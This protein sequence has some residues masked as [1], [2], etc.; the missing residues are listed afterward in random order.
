MA[1]L[2]AH[3]VRRSMWPRCLLVLL[4]VVWPLTVVSGAF[5]EQILKEWQFNR[6][7]DLEGWSPGGHVRET[8]VSDGVLRTTVIDW[9]PILIH[10]VFAEPLPA[11]ATQVIEIR[12][13]AP[14]A[15]RAEFFWTNTTQTQY[16]GFSPGKQ[17][18]F[19]L[20]PGWHTYQVRPFWQAEGQIIR[21]RLDLPPLEGAESP[22]EY[23]IDF[24]R[25]LELGAGGPPANPDWSFSQDTR[26]WQVEGDGKIWWQDGCLQAEL[27]AGARLV[28]PPFTADADVVGFVSFE[29]A[30]DQPGSGRIFWA[31]GKVNGLQSQDF[32]L[33]S[34]REFRVYNIPLIGSKGW[35]SPLVYLAIAPNISQPTRIRLRWFKLTEE[36]AGP[37]DLEIERLFIRSALPRVGQPQE[38]VAR[39]ANRGGQTATRV[40]AELTLPAGWRVLEPQTPR[41]IVESIEFGD[42]ADVIWRVVS[43]QAGPAT[44]RV[45]ILSPTA[46][47]AACEENILPPMSLPKADYVPEPKPVRGPY[48]VGVY[49]FPGW[50]RPG[51]WVPI[52]GFPERRP[53]LG[54]YREGL[55]E[56]ADWHIKWAVEHGIT[57]FCY[58]WYWTQGKRMLEH[59]LHDGF[60]NARYRHLMKFCLLWANH[61]GPG[62]HSAEDNERVCR[63]WIENYFRRPEYFKVEGRPLVV[64]FSVHSMQRDLGIEGTRQAIELWHKMTEEAGVGKILVAGC[65]LPSQ[66]KKMKEMGFDAVS[67]YNWPSCGI[68]DRNWVP[69]AE[70]A[71]NYDRLWWRPLAEANLMPVIT[72]ISAG[73]DSRPWHGDK[74]LVITD[75]TPQA[76]EEHL[77]QARRFVEETHQPKV[78]LIE[79]WNEFGEGSYCEPHKQYGFGHLEAVRKVFCP[80]SPASL[81]Y[82]PEDVG[83]ALPEFAE[84][85]RPRLRTQWGFDTPGNPEGWEMMMGL[86][87]LQ[88]ADGLLT[89]RTT[90]TDP[91][92]VC[93]TRFRARDFVAL[94][95]KIAIASSRPEEILQLYWATPSAPYREEASARTHVTADGTLRVYRIELASH[96]MWRGWVTGL[97]LDTGSTPDATVKI[98]QI[99][100]VPAGESPQQ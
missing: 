66:L 52:D 97:R 69:F 76:F 99:R 81:N 21:L 82:G 75:C 61:F 28:A 72:P 67:G 44:L 70:V 46:A 2:I 51:S 34:G 89:A 41:R 20:Q 57:F 79:A 15:G 47:E 77:H 12:M 64:I 36:P 48:E 30:S 24:I 58:D 22:P 78:V 43:D 33:A 86:S 45:Q 53:V 14:R 62:E 87:D 84:V 54:Y 37:A 96:P 94:E 50:G 19:D 85:H 10:D 90:T 73:W 9:D 56:I 40:Q 13:Y 17:T 6:P 1:E 98:D 26:G 39:I 7:G 11:T 55:P 95:V 65:G 71:A 60:F 80:D 49:Y 5:G 59:A 68:G 88:V 29:M 4:G 35:Q 93:Q 38:V 91:A 100:L 42:R 3:R 27:A 74:A 63:F 31:S 18:V 32:R 8:R 25:I 23:Q 83:L 16:G 92:F